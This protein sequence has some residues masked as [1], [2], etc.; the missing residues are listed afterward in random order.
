MSRTLFHSALVLLAATSATL[1]QTSREPVVF[2]VFD[3][4][5][6]HHGCIARARS[7]NGGL[8]ELVLGRCDS[9]AAQF[10]FDEQAKRIR[11]AS[12]PT[13]C[14][15][16]PTGSGAAPF[17]ALLRDCKDEG[18]G[19]FYSYN[20]S[21]KRIVSLNESNRED[22][23]SFC[24]FAG[25]QRG[26]RIPILT[27]PCNGRN[28]R[29]GQIVFYLKPRSAIAG[30]APA[31]TGA[32]PPA[33]L[34]GAA[35]APA[36]AQQATRTPWGPSGSWT[37][38]SSGTARGFSACRASR[39]TDSGEIRVALDPALNI[40]MSTP[41]DRVTVPPGT[42]AN[43][44]LTVGRDAET[45]SGTVGPDS[46]LG[47][48]LPTPL[49]RTMV[50]RPPREMLIEAPDGMSLVPLAGFRAVWN[51]LNACVNAQGRR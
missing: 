13:L 42:N 49:A 11:S 12:D 28:A 3:E 5:L 26:Q 17:S 46:R 16:D 29:E 4:P 30:A 39:T 25:R 23:D 34:P 18:I 10:F 36:S 51:E 24:F 40:T 32:A 50:E 44:K 35:P 48:P 2:A 19:Q 9:P 47:F 20:R 41:V 43:V 7:T 37:I 27:E 6:P 22:R 33:P 21:S 15:S 31:A 14:W 38:E 1:A 45:V 8:D